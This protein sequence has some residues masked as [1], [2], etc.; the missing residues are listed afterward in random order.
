M[1][2]IVASSPS[3]TNAVCRALVALKPRGPDS[4][5]LLE[6]ASC[7]LGVARLSVSDL[8]G[9]NQPITSRSGRSHIA[10]NGA[11]Y[12]AAEL[13]RVFELDVATHNDAEVALALYEL[14]GVTFTDHLDGMYAFIISDDRGD[15]LIFGVDEIGIKPLHVA[16]TGNSIFLCSTLQALGRPELALAQRVPP[17]TVW[18]LSGLR[19]ITRSRAP[20]KHWTVALESAVEAQI[21]QE[22]PWGCLLSGGLD[23]AVLCKLA[24]RTR[25]ITTITC[26]V[27][28]NSAD[29]RAARQVADILG[30]C[31]HEE[32][33]TP[34]DLR[35]LAADVVA[36]TAS[37][38]P[39]L[40]LGGMGTLAASRAAARLRIKV[41]LTGEGADELFGG[42]RDFDQVPANR[43]EQELRHQQSQLGATECLR[44]DRCSAAAGIEARVPYLSREV[45]A[46]VRSLP[47]A[48][49][50]SQPGSAKSI[51]KV[52]LRRYATSLN[53]PEDVAWRPKIGFS[54]GTGLDSLLLEMASSERTIW[55]S[56]TDRSRFAPSG[57]D[58][59]EPMLAWLLGMW[60]ETY[61]D[62]LAPN[63]AD[64]RQRGL[65]RS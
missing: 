8:L 22:V 34:S 3:Q 24:S 62:A 52:A 27:A 39:W 29:L 11:I 61:G 6:T 38:E 48:A 32:L 17:G 54:N 46:A 5:G 21:P 19:H 47:V 36:A 4:T 63:W 7:T 23:S 18:D 60:L 25:N 2:G 12:N 14:L 53:L 41:L 16:S 49:K 58:P 56:P 28:D 57:L 40:V 20:H 37:F 43:L 9:G 42:Y 35:S 45:V 33:I 10:F 44:L 26:G 65:V 15:N 50:R 30:C 64:M 13:I 31:H 55:A 51:T 1:C 59:N